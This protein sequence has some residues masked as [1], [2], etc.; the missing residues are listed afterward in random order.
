METR[1]EA[2]EEVDESEDGRESWLKEA[3]ATC[4]VASSEA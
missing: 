3:T 1:K 2:M 4:V